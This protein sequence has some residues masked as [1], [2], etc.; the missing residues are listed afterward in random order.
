VTG[1]IHSPLTPV[2]HI[3]PGLAHDDA[4]RYVGERGGGGQPGPQRVTGVFARVEACGISAAFDD[5]CHALVVEART[6]YLARSRERPEDG[7]AFD[8][9][10]MQPV[11]ERSDGTG[12]RVLP[13]WQAHFPADP[14]LVRL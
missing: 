1:V 12:L 2:T 3:M 5:Q 9:R 8:R 11:A 4:L 7:A 13:E 6:A 14:L 10:C